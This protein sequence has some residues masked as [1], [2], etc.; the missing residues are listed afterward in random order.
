MK[1]L[2][3]SP[4]CSENPDGNVEIRIQCQP[5]ASKTEITG[6][7]GNA[8]KIRVTA[9][10]VDGAANKELCKMLAKYFEVSRQA[11]QI[12]SGQATRQKRILIK[13]RTVQDINDRLSGLMG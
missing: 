11:I 1:V 7:H 2:N 4:F 10:P 5:R 3:D 12:L 13:G 6:F 8:L 9:S